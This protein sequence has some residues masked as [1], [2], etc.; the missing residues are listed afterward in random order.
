MSIPPSPP[1]APQPPQPPHQTPQQ[2]F[3]QSAPLPP[4]G[5]PPNGT[6]PFPPSVPQYAPGQTPPPAPVGAPVKRRNPVVRI[7][8]AIV[9]LLVVSGGFYAFRYFTDDAARASVGQC[10]NLTGTEHDPTIEMLDCNSDNAKLKVAKVLDSATGSCPNA[11]YS[12]YYK[13]SSRGPSYKLCL[14]PN[15]VEGQ[16]YKIGA[17]GKDTDFSKAPCGSGDVVKVAKVIQGSA[18]EKACPGGGGVS[19][20]EPPTTFCVTRGDS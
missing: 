15:L 19:Y 11:D 7:V 2:G 10:A 20:P 4:G 5:Q 3:P 12:E 9:V 18:D 6:P 17:S 8:V 14:V 1:G 13:S 16:C